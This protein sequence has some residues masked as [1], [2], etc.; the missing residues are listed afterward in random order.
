MRAED[1]V[2]WLDVLRG[3]D[4]PES[5]LDPSGRGVLCKRHADSMIVPRD[6]TLDDLREPDLHLFRPPE[7]GA[8][9]GRP[10]RRRSEPR[11]RSADQLTL[12]VDPVPDAMPD[13][14]PD[15]E[16]GAE[17][18]SLPD[19]VPDAETG[20]E[21]GSL[22]DP[23]PDADPGSTTGTGS[24]PAATE[25]APDPEPVEPWTPSFDDGDDL[26]GLLAARSP[27]LA[28]A[29]RGTDRTKGS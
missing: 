24:P 5:D 15:A 1:L 11:E 2:F 4:D 22:P 9:A 14:M 25:P 21:V 13:A 6:W 7:T 28:R 29:F 12:G 23:L 3:E 26:D 27:L 17:V 16:T 19:P 8:A 18:G 10:T 20:A